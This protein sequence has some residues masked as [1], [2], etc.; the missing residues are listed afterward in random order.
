MWLS[1]WWLRLSLSQHLSSTNKTINPDTSGFIVLVAPSRSYRVRQYI[2]AA[3]KLNFQ[4]VIISDSKHSLVSAIANGITISFQNIEKAFKTVIREIKDLTIKGVISTDDLCAPLS[5]RIAA[6]F[7]LPHNDDKAAQLTYRKDLARITLEQQGCNVPNFAIIDKQNPKFPTQLTFPVVLKPL[8][9]SGSRGVIRANNL[10]DY[11]SAY[12]TIF[13]IIDDPAY[14]DYER[15]HILIE[16]YLE[17]F[18]VALDAFI[19]GDNFKVLAIFEKPEPLTGPYFEESYY[20]TP[21]QHADSIQQNIINEIKRCCKAYGL[22]FGAIH[23]EARITA[24]GVFTIEIASRTIG[25]QCSQ[26]LEYSLGLP[27][28]EII[29]QL[30]NKQAIKPQQ[31]HLFPGVLMIPIQKAGLLKRVEGL[32]AANQIKYVKDI[33]IHIQPGYELIPLPEGQSYLG[34]IFAVSDSFETTFSA[35]KSAFEQ[36]KFVTQ[37]TWHIK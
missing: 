13:N 4:L 31:N 30:I 1:G 12:Q 25:G 5:S 24:E 28:E 6:Y 33:E 22:R 23:A 35:L 17:G 21:S 19:D 2:D 37:K 26:L 36:L 14:S 32:L 9:L 10:K 29:L 34:F 18:E 27:L 7:N 15:N 11:E 3:H 8:M 20:I 16:Q